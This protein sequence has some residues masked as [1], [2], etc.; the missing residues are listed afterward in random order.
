MGSSVPKLVVP[1]G[2][3][4]KFNFIPSKRNRLYDICSCVISSLSTRM[5]QTIRQ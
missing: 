4:R 3:H 5:I 1:I 2:I